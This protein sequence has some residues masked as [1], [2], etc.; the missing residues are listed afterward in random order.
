MRLK[1][2]GNELKIE[3]DRDQLLRMAQEL[4]G[5]SIAP[6]IRERGQLGSTHFV[7]DQKMNGLEG[8]YFVRT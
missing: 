5:L 4:I 7:F 6:A 1:I 2:V 8:C 3:G